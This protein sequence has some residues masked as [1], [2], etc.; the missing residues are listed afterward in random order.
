MLTLVLVYQ[1]FAGGIGTAGRVAHTALAHVARLAGLGLEFADNEAVTT[2]IGVE[3]TLR[4]AVTEAGIA[5]AGFEERHLLVAL[6]FVGGH[7]SAALVAG[8]FLG[9]I[10]RGNVGTFLAGGFTGHGERRSGLG[11]DYRGS[12]EIQAAKKCGNK[13]SFHG[14][15]WG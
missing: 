13:Q 6:Y 11:M 2:A 5:G 12:S 1:W 9:I 14:T 15:Q 3:L 4:A 10:G 8:Q 7:G